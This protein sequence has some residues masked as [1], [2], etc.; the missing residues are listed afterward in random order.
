MYKNTIDRNTVTIDLPNGIY[1]FD[2]YSA[3]G[4]TRLFRL[5]RDLQKQG[6]PIFTFTYDDKLLFGLQLS[7]ILGSNRFEIIMLDRYDMYK[8]DG[9]LELEQHRKSCVVL[10]DCKSALPG[11]IEYE[12][13]LIET[14]K[15]SIEVYS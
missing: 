12:I 14:T 5:L 6:E 13:A 3:T 11:D 8:G 2:G 9:F 10:L 7:E 1:T 15:D 4:K